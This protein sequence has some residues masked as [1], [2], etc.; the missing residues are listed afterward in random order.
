LM[1]S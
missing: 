1:R